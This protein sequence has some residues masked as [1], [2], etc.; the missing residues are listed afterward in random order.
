MGSLPHVRLTLK[1]EQ[2]D[3]P[4]SDSWPIGRRVAIGREIR[5]R[6]LR[7]HSSMSTDGSPGADRKD[8][9]KTGQRAQGHVNV[10]DLARNPRSE[11]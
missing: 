6:N 2:A 1:S 4:V 8:R 7:S 3:Q 11:R 10:D 5:P 9:G